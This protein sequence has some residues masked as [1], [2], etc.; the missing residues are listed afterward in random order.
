MGGEGFPARLGV[1]ALRV[2]LLHEP[3]AHA[4]DEGD[5]PG[6]FLQRFFAPTQPVEG[7]CAVAQPVEPGFGR[8][9]IAGGERAVETSERLLRTV[10]REEDVSPIAIQGGPILDEHECLGLMEHGQRLVGST[11][12]LGGNGRLHEGGAQL[13][14]VPLRRARAMA[15]PN[16]SAARAGSPCHNRV[17]AT[18]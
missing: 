14:L 12:A 2:V 1:A 10:Q 16:T 9:T 8:R 7:L 3:G 15:C 6:R 17:T 13:P 11:G 18:P 4:L 5:R